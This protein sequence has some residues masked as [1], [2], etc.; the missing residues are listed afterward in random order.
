ML[1]A[2]VRRDDTGELA[3]LIA[4]L[5]DVVDLVLADLDD[6]IKCM[7]LLNVQLRNSYLQHPLLHAAYADHPA[8]D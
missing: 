1:P 3:R 4:C 7:K 8:Q 6:V 2:H 5:Q